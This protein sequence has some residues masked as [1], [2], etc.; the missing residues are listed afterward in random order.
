MKKYESD[1][2]KT[3]KSQK[4]NYLFLILAICVGG[5][6]F[7]KLL[8]PSSSS[9]V[10][11]EEETVFDLPGTG[12]NPQEMRLVGIENDLMEQEKLS[13]ALLEQQLEMKELLFDL[14][15]SV[16]HQEL[17]QEGLTAEDLKNFKD[18]IFL[19][20]EETKASSYHEEEEVDLVFAAPAENS[21][22]KHVS[23][24][25]PAGTMVRCV[26]V[27]AA[28]CSVGVSQASDPAT[29]LLRPLSNGKLPRGVRV[30]LKD[31]IIL[32]RG[33]GDL[34]NER[35]RIR[36]EKM[37]LVHPNGEF[38]ETEISAFVSGEDGR[39]GM[40]GVVVDRA[41]SSIFR[42]AAA[43]TVQGISSSIQATLNNQTLSK[44]SKESDSRVILDVDTFRNAGIQGATTGLNQ[45]ADYYIKRAEQ[46]Q[47]SI[48]IAAGRVVDLIFT[49]GVKIGE[50]DLKKKFQIERELAKAKKG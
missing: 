16:E 31:S 3:R 40:R 38:I 2:E 27:S 11:E 34:A 41:G 4:R 25:I 39:E 6:L 42:A 10:F 5:A 15:T 50:K 46:L 44:L 12:I 17:P 33:V 8:F 1:K 43:S 49:T 37:T 22:K 28:D 45:L 23:A 26:L 20:L 14:K 7:F 21:E 47:P 19:E 9:S 24:Y 30:A 32:G 18:E 35:V 13:K 48:Q 36:G 29:V